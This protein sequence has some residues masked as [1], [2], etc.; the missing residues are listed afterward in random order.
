MQGES[1]DCACCACR[2]HTHYHEKT[3]REPHWTQ[4]ESNAMALCC[5]EG[6]PYYGFQHC[7]FTACLHR[8]PCTMHG[9]CEKPGPSRQRRL[10]PARGTQECRQTH[11]RGNT[12]P[13]G[14]L[15]TVAASPAAAGRR[16]MAV[17]GVAMSCGHRCADDVPGAVPL[18]ATWSPAARAHPPGGPAPRTG[19]PGASPAHREARL[20]K[21]V[22][23]EGI[24]CVND[25]SKM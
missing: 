14:V 21:E 6:Y 7:S 1:A 3:V 11:V 17:H 20:S 4:R 2:L 24:V 23:T 9:Q 10:Q 13:A 25:A 19:S 16:I 12:C 5:H 18:T 8:A 22:W 15:P